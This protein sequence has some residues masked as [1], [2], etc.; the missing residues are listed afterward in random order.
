MASGAIDEGAVG[1]VL[2]VMDEDGPEVDE[3]EQEDVG[4]LLQWEDEGE[5]VI[6][7]ALGPAV[8][9]VKGVRGEGTRHDPLVVRL[10]QSLVDAGVVQPTVDPVD[11]EIGEE[12]EER[13]LQDAVVREGLIG[14]GIVELGIASNLQDEERRCQKSH[15]G[16]GA[17]GLLHFHG[18]LVLEEL[19]MV[20]S[21]LVPDEDVR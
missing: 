10:V 17:H 14:D 3:A 13:E 4:Q 15:R 8:Q 12:D 20:V 5:D 19:G 6:R 16:H 1:H 9:G 11:E 21:R 2:T 7:H 18:N